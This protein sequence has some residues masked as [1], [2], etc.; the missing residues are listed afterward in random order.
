MK[1]INLE[2]YLQE[3]KKSTL[4]LFDDKRC[5]INETEKK[6]LKIILFKDCKSKRILQNTSHVKNND[7]SKNIFYAGKEM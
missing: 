3:V 4:S 1:S 2:M 5:Y 7:K 6:N